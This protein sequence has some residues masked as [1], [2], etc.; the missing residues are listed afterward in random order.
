MKIRIIGKI[1]L[2]LM[3]AACSTQRDTTSTTTRHAAVTMAT[4]S[5]QGS[6]PPSNLSLPSTQI[7]RGG[8]GGTQ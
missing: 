8:L 3:L 5:S 4:S 2:S 1:F 7:F 6:T